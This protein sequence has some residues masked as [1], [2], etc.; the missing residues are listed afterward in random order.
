MLFYWNLELF[1]NYITF[2]GN[3]LPIMELRVVELAHQR[4]LT[5][6][7]I[8]KTVGISRVNLSN[9]LNGNPT[10]SRLK[11]VA[12]IL[13]VEVAELFKPTSTGKTV[14]GYLEYDGRIVKVDSL[15]AVKRFIAEVEAT[16]D[17]RDE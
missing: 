3:T 6:S 8:A 13:D 15:D 4:G 12:K 11:E 7:D 14:S 16:V 1:F 17:N 2:D 5:M 10:L 9:S